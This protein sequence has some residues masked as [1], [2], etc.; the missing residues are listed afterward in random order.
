MDI[1]GYLREHEILYSGNSLMMGKNTLALPERLIT[2]FREKIKENT[3]E[4]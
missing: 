1:E 4:R 3:S 2:E